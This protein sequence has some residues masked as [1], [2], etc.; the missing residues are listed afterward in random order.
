MSDSEAAPLP[1]A[2]HPLVFDYRNHEGQISTRTVVPLSIELTTTDWHKDE[3]W[4]IR[5]RD[6]SRPN[7]AIRDFAV[8]NINPA[9]RPAVLA[10]VAQ[11]RDVLASGTAADTRDLKTWIS[12]LETA[13]PAL[14]RTEPKPA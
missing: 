4:L 11:M 8:G 10:V 1:N 12:A 5:A 7:G 13:V 3:D 2:D 9:D 14:T 6:L